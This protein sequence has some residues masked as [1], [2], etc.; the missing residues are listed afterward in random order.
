[1]LGSLDVTTGDALRSFHDALDQAQQSLQRD[2]KRLSATVQLLSDLT[3]EVDHLKAERA[4]SSATCQRREALQAEKVKALQHTRHQR[5]AIA[6]TADHIQH[7]QAPRLKLTK[8]VDALKIDVKV[9]RRQYGLR[10]AQVHAFIAQ[11]LQPQNSLENLRCQLAQLQQERATQAEAVKMAQRRL[12]E[13]KADLAALEAADRLGTTS[14]SNGGAIA[15]NGKAPRTKSGDEA[16]AV[17]TLAT[18]GNDVQLDAADEECAADVPLFTEAERRAEATR[19]R[20]AQVAAHKSAETQQVEER[21][22]LEALRVDLKRQVLLL[23][24]EIEEADA[25]QQQ[26]QKAYHDALNGA[27]GE[28]DGGVLRQCKRCSCDLFGG[29]S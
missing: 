28:A 11:F 25:A 22:R 6:A 5:E 17:L 12:E 9:L 18:D 7:L 23:C 14:D 13:Q 24:Q 2:E 19:R 4:P 8:R 3:L 21:T 26:E 1:M 29:F 15:G 16:A 10:A 27:V 20:S